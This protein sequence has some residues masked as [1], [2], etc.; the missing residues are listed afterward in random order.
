MREHLLETL[1][2]VDYAGFLV[3]LMGP[4]KAYTIDDFVDDPEP[5]GVDPDAVGLG[6]WEEGS[7]AY[8]EDETL[9]LLTAVRDDLREHD[10]NAFLAIDVGIELDE[11]DAASQSIAFAR[12][13]NV[14]ALIAPE[15]GKNLGVGIETGAVLEAL[16]GADQERVV[17]LHERNV[18]SAMIRS[19]S[20]RWEATVYAWSDREELVRKLREFAVD[21]MHRELYGELTP[22][23]TEDIH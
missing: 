19:L 7:S 6:T 4:Y 9:D 15:V 21:V 16:T 2:A 12:A 11:M 1:P 3:Y 13:S 8:D 23:H 18:S 17:F 5:V 10:L 22:R 20:R 14:V